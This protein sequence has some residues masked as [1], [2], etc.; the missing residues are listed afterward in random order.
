MELEFDGLVVL[1]VEAE[2]A[3][4]EDYAVRVFVTGTTELPYVRSFRARFD[5]EPIEGVARDVYG[6]GFTG[7]L[8][9]EPDQGARLFVE[10]DGQDEVDTGL[11]YSRDTGPI[12]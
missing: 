6:T 8:K 5:D 4:L 12:A 2:D 1:D 7:Y 9:N 3:L 10:F 11:T